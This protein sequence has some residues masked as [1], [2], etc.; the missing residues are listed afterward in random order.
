MLGAPEVA[1]L[2]DT[3]LGVQQQV[4]RFDIPA[5]LIQFSANAINQSQDIILD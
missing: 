1:E 2:E 4:L 5:P 3:T